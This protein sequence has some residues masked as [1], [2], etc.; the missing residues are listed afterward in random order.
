MI[1]PIVLIVAFIAL[2]S[3]VDTAR[4]ETAVP[5]LTVY[6]QLCPTR[7]PQVE[8]LDIVEARRLRGVDYTALEKVSMASADTIQFLGDL[9][10]RQQGELES[11][12]TSTAYISQISRNAVFQNMSSAAMPSSEIVIAPEA[13]CQ[14]IPL[15]ERLS[16]QSIVFNPQLRSALD[17]K[18]IALTLS[19]FAFSSPLNALA[20][21]PNPPSL[22]AR[23]I[24]SYF[25]SGELSPRTRPLVVDALQRMSV[26]NFRIQGLEINLREPFSFDA[27]GILLSATPAANSLWKFQGNQYPVRDIAV[28]FHGNG[29]VRS[30]CPSKP[31]DYVDQF[32]N[33]LSLFCTLD[34]SSFDRGAQPIH[35]H[36]NGFLARGRS[37]TPAKIRTPL[38]DVHLTPRKQRFETVDNA[39][40][41]ATEN[42][43]Y[44]LLS[45]ASGAL[46]LDSAW[47]RI[48]DNQSVS[49]FDDG[50]LKET[51]L[52]DTITV[53]IQNETISITSWIDFSAPGILNSAE[54]VEEVCLFRKE[55]RRQCFP[56]GERLYFFNGLVL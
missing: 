32:N 23:L 41:V 49:F 39:L 10:Q 54:I 36:Q 15:A 22:Y 11:V 55:G 31:I 7:T 14:Y 6:G 27:D 40:V 19:S 35:F 16:D 51:I 52:N 1:K 2:W 46:F 42:G 24:H 53:V 38:V 3:T 12:A 17:G 18:L 28:Y 8:L 25:L 33:R 4:A 47:R 29:T 20:T 9:F 50:S 34:L 44:T 45:N 37:S 48:E 43:L 26:F 30:I 21:K 56:R 5:K 13:G